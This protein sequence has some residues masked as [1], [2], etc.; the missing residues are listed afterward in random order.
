MALSPP[1][2][3][4]CKLKEDGSIRPNRPGP[5]KLVREVLRMELFFVI[6]RAMQSS[7]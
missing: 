5:R 6:I 4:I 7:L 2:I 1:S 3:N